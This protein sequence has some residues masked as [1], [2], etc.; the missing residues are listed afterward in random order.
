MGD[1]DSSR[2]SL[3][4]KAVELAPD[5]AGYLDTLAEIHFQRGDK[6][7][8]VALQKR[9]VELDP[10]RSYYRKQLRRLEAGDPSAERPPEDQD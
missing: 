1:S 7:K 2:R 5:N 8:A 4:V 6:D 3:G 9:V 10:K